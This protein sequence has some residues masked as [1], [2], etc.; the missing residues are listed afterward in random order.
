MPFFSDASR[1]R[2]ARA[3][4]FGRHIKVHRLAGAEWTGDS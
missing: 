1:E 2:L 3:P 4:L